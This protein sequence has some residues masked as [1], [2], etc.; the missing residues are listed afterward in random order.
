M[1]FPRSRTT[2]FG[3]VALAALVL[4]A[5]AQAAISPDAAHSPN[6]EDQ[7]LA[8]WVTLVIATLIALALVG[9]LLMAVRRF[10]SAD[11]AAEPRRLTAGRG[12][13]AKAGAGLGLIV[14]VV[15]IFGVVV[16]SGVKNATAE[17]GVE[18]IEINAI[19]QQW[20]WRFEYPVQAE[21]SFS[22]GISTVFSYN[23][24]VVPVDTLVQLNIDST[25]IIHSWSV[26]ALGP[27]VWAMPGTIVETSFIADE[28]GVYR[29]RSM[30]FSGSSFPFMRTTVRVVSQDA[31]E[32]FL[33]GLTT[34][35]SAGQEA[36]QEA[37]AAEEAAED[38]AATSEDDAAEDEAT[39]E[40][41]S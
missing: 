13:I 29:G 10:R 35:L 1:R 22:E 27:N 11:G 31:Y 14:L 37:A 26:P 24:L 38:S 34:D 17:E 28:E 3:L 15:F 20:L 2:I 7:R 30:V 12:V 39:S 25:D 6:A 19:A 8:F 36:V 4:A 32:T 41:G 23:E 33:D 9:G 21:G 18:E 40:D 16:S 5:P